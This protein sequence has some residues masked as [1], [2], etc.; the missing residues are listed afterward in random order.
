M[1]FRNHYWEHVD[2]G[3]CI[4]EIIAYTLPLRLLLIINLALELYLL[5]ENYSQI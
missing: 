2:M 1:L 4:T 5:Q 3:L